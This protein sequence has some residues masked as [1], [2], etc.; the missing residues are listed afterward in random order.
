MDFRPPAV[1]Y[2]NE[3]QLW[4]RIPTNDYAVSMRQNVCSA[5]K[6]QT[7]SEMSVKL[8]GLEKLLKAL[9][10][11]PPIAKV[12]VL[13]NDAGRSGGG[14]N[15]VIGAAHEFGTSTL[16]VR[17]WLRVPIN[18]YLN[19]QLKASGAFDKE[20]LK[21]VINS[22]SLIP[23]TKK[24]ALVA[25]S[26]VLEGF[27]TNGYGKWPQSDYTKKTNAQTLVETGQLRNAVSTEVKE[28]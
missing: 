4:C 21:Q 25:E 15:A 27:D 20:T 8:E 23:W 5:W 6:Y 22:G 18:D 24:L 3:N 19:A 7:M 12:G 1:F 14:N 17:S 2:A 9:K 11:K 13:S 28:G 16:P 10:A 26:I